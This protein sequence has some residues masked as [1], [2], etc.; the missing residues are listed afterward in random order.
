M[1]GKRHGVSLRSIAGGD[2]NDIRKAW[3]IRPV[4]KMI[5]RGPKP[6]ESDL[7]FQVLDLTLEL[8]LSL[9]SFI[10]ALLAGSGLA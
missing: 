4:M 6:E 9:I 2:Q 1:S 3:S 7:G 8:F 5:K 10:I